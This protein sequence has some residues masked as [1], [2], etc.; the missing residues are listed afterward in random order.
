MW[1][2]LFTFYKY[3]SGIHLWYTSQ[4]DSF[5]WRRNWKQTNVYHERYS[6]SKLSLEIIYIYSIVI[7]LVLDEFD[8]IDRSNQTLVLL[9]PAG[10][11]VPLHDLGDIVKQ[12]S[13]CCC[14][15]LKLMFTDL[16]QPTSDLAL[17]LLLFVNQIPS[18]WF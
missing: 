3:V 18:K 15:T 14:W 5:Q 6:I 17:V 1:V 9:T 12:Y 4:I 16:V 7:S 8:E 11:I 10:S 2:N 13:G